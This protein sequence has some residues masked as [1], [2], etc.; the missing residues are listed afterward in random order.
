MLVPGIVGSVRT[1]FTLEE[2]FFMLYFVNRPLQ[3]SGGKKKK[4]MG[5]ET[6]TH[7]H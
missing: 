2:A 1:F 3:E 5:Y 6:Q 4:A 7:A